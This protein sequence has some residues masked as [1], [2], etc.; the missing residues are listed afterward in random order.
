M[1]I[2]EIGFF[3]GTV[4]P[5]DMRL[6]EKLNEVIRGFNGLYDAVEA[7]SHSIPPKAPTSPTPEEM[8]YI[9]LDEDSLR[10]FH[11]SPEGQELGRRYNQ[12]VRDRTESSISEILQ[13][14]NR[15][16]EMRIHF[17]KAIQMLKAI[18][19]GEAPDGHPD[20]RKDPRF[21]TGGISGVRLLA[22]VAMDELETAL[23]GADALQEPQNKGKEN[24]NH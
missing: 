16:Q 2:E 1:K 24:E 11:E 13:R 20:C 9:K 7:L 8:G 17:G 15:F 22:Q 19:S 21:T 4:S 23:A 12:I 14:E 18:A 3:A 5:A 6:A 10:R